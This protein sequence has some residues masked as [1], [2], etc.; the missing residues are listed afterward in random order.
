VAA[1]RAADIP[2]V[3]TRSHYFS[4][5]PIEGAIAIGPGLH[6]R[7]DWLPAL[8]NELDPGPVGLA[9]L[10]GWFGEMQSVSQFP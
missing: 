6:Q 5:A 10:R 4:A 3:V 7:Q 9:E 8:P 1:A 2:V